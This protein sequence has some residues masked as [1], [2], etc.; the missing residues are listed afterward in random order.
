M[1][2]TIGRLFRATTFGESHGAC[3]GA[4]VDGC[5]SGL[6]LDERDIQ[7]QLDRRRPGQSSLTSPRGEADRVRIVSGVENGLTLGSPIALLVD[8]ADMKPGDYEALRAVP[9]PSHAD[10]T[11]KVKYGVTAV[12]GGG[13]AS[14]RETI[15]RVAAGAVAEKLLRQRHGVGIVAWVSG[16]GDVTAEAQNPAEV[17][18]AQVDASP[19]RC[20]DVEAA[21]RMR[22]LIEQAAAEGDSLGGTIT[23]VCRNVPAGWGEPVFGK[24]HAALAGAVMS[25]PAVKGFEIG[26]GFAGARMRGS[27]HNDP[28]VMR[29]GRLG[30]SSNR[31]GGVQGGISNGEPIVFRVAFKPV[32][33]IRAAQKT[34]DYDG[35]P[36]VLQ[37]AKGRHDP[38]VLPRAVPIVEAMAALVL[39]DMALIARAALAGLRRDAQD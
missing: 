7:P 15:G 20:P 33:T 21:G 34:V 27:E 1:S 16:V 2:N 12:S 13:R 38:C 3:V 17:G 36:V 9:R 18:R 26:S 14:A 19:V 39:A 22:A 6:A 10:Y 37:V 32:A 28:F 30:T 8:N 35:K 4:V 25:I 5:P 11:Y 31:S 29:A 24:M 23:C